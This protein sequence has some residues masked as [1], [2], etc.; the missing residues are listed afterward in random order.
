M[1]RFRLLLPLLIALP[2]MSH[3]EIR[4]IKAGETTWLWLTGQG[5]QAQ[6]QSDLAARVPTS[7][8]PWLKEL[9]RLGA[10]KGTEWEWLTK[11]LASPP[12]GIVAA[13]IRA[14]LEVSGS[15]VHLVSGGS[16]L[17]LKNDGWPKDSANAKSADAFLD[18]NLKL[19]KG[20]TRTA[21]GK[22]SGG[23]SAIL[24]QR[25]PLLVE[26]GGKALLV[27]VADAPTSASPGTTG[28]TPTTPTPTNPTPTQA[29]TGETKKDNDGLPVL[30][31]GLGGFL[32]G[33]IVAMLFAIVRMKKP[34]PA[35]GPTFEQSVANLR[36]SAPDELRNLPG[37]PEEWM[38][39]VFKSYRTARKKADGYDEAVARLKGVEQREQAVGQV[40]GQL[41]QREARVSEIEQR[42]K[43]TA[44]SLQSTKA[45]LDE[46]TRIADTLSKD[47]AARDAEVIRRNDQAADLAELV[48]IGDAAAADAQRE[49]SDRMDLAA[50]IASL[51]RHSLAH[52]ALA[53]ESC[54]PNLERA[55]VENLIRIGEL[56]IFNTFTQLAER[57]TAYAEKWLKDVPNLPKSSQ[58]HR[59][60]RD[61]Q[62]QLN[63]LK[64]QRGMR[65]SPYALGVD[66]QGA[67]MHVV[68]GL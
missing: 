18:E 35:S 8:D 44:A 41:A 1:S 17:D 59:L 15:E 63:F 7:S 49:L 58:Q 45:A 67:P 16:T 20:A 56:R 10:K 36:K 23:W 21:V 27:Q 47:R 4:F 46:K 64:D 37:G 28:A 60:H 3:A 42:Y 57:A 38:R 51:I 66:A 11:Q 26:G 43:T 31:A 29:K 33:A 12:K 14:K 22:F 9:H 54:D 6:T 40:E 30:L 19:G 2:V 53:A 55:M 50:I 32:G 39:E 68:L 5:P 34:A 65:I 13:P 48:Q 52:L 61:F 25:G 62:A 24:A